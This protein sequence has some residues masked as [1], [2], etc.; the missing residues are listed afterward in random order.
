MVHRLLGASSALQVAELSSWA[1]ESASADQH[2]R[3]ASHLSTDR[4][5]ALSLLWGQSF[6]SVAD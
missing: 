5:I 2:S 4:S 1:R 3:G 6:V